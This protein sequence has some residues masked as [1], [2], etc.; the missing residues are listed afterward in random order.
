MQIIS[1][2]RDK[3]Q[4]P[5]DTPK[6]EINSSGFSAGAY[7]TINNQDFEVS[8]VQVNQSADVI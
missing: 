2:Q 6:Q 8:L 4:E 1:R 5:L 7:E 3:S